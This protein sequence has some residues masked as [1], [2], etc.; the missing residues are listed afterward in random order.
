MVK[1]RLRDELEEQ[2]N[3]FGSYDLVMSW[4][5]KKN[6]DSILWRMQRHVDRPPL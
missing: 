5:M 4:K 3:T 1:T 6:V 2:N